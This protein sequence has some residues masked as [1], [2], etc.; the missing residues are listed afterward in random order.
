MF[1]QF[2]FDEQWKTLKS[3]ANRHGI[4]LIGDIPIYV[5]LDSADVW[6][7]KEIF[8]LNPEL[9]ASELSGCPPDCF[10]PD[11]QLWGNPVYDWKKLKKQKYSWWI[12]RLNQS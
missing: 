4:S 2:K 9:K 5:A 7:N 3:Y 11:G 8:K 6:A 12:E 1:L 10:S